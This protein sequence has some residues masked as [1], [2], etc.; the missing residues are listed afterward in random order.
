MVLAGL[1]ISAMFSAGLSFMQYIATDS[2]LGNI[3]LW[4]FGFGQNHLV[5]G[6]SDTHRLYPRRLYI[7]LGDGTTMPW[8]PVRTAQKGAGREHGKGANARNGPCFAPQCHSG[9]FLPA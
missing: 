5:M 6:F 2:Q 7:F 4:M 3:I 8:R 9:L 1:A